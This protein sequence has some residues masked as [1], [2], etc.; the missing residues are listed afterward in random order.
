MSFN[1]SNQMKQELMDKA[2]EEAERGLP[3]NVTDELLRMVEQ[4]QQIAAVMTMPGWEVIEGILLKELQFSQS[5]SDAA[6]NKLEVAQTFRIGIVAGM[7]TRIYKLPHIA[8][9]AKKMLEK[10]AKRREKHADRK[11]SGG[12]IARRGIWFGAGG[13]RESA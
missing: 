10:E 3:K 9:K 1:P 6:E 12:G 7:L 2:G 8:E 5:I 11:R 4:G 13:K